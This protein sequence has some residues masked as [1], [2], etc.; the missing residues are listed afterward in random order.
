MELGLALVRAVVGG[1]FMGHGLQKLAGWFGGH[2]LKATGQAFES[3]E[4][5]PGVAHAAAAGAAET[6]G[7]AMLA[8]GLETPVAGALLSGTMITAIRKVHAANGP[9]ASNGGY[10]YN[11]VLLAAV[12]AICDVGPGRLSIDGARGRPRYGPAWAFG[13]LAAGAVGSALA[14]AIGA[15]QS[16][17]GASGE[18]A[19]SAVP[20]QDNGG[21]AQ[22]AAAGAEPS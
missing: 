7:G 3:M 11:L 22:P 5:R 21:V 13:Q 16:A 12:F 10:E 15:R 8:L 4:L 6:G 18:A 20:G 2:G 1:L 14:I 17:A 9:W 19:E